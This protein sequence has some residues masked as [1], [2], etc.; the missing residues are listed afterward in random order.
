M[1]Y[2]LFTLNTVFPVFII[3]FIGFLLKKI[4]FINEDF[5]SVSSNLVYKVALPSLIFI[6]V[7]N[8]N[9]KE[10]AVFSEILFAVLFLTIVFILC[11]IFRLIF[12]KDK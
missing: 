5:I 8:V 6:K 2:F 9:I 12:I 1:E 3:I 11:L 7:S 10:L 4:N